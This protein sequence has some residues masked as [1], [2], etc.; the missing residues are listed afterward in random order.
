ML[1]NHSAL[2]IA[3]YYRGHV[4]GYGREHLNVHTKRQVNGDVKEIL[5][6]YDCN[7]LFHAD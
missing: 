5:K 2:V 1:R 6:D 7:L 3:R 4:N